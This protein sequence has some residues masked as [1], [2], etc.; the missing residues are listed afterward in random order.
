MP[1]RAGPRRPTARTRSPRR[2]RAP[3]RTSRPRRRGRPGAGRPARGSGRPGRTRRARSRRP[4]RD[5]SRARAGAAIS[6]TPSGSPRSYTTSTANTERGVVTPVPI[7]RGQREAELREGPARRLLVTQL[8]LHRGAQPVETAA[9]R[10]R[11]DRVDHA[12]ELTEPELLAS[13]HAQLHE[14][15]RS[16]ERHRRGRRLLL[17]LQTDP[18]R[19]VHRRRRQRERRAHRPEH[20]LHPDVTATPGPRDVAVDVGPAPGVAQPE[21]GDLGQRPRWPRSRGRAAPARAVARRG[22]R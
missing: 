14:A 8:E 11:Q 19:L 2:G 21:A 17:R 18:V 6:P 16:G 5:R 13:D 4:G 15:S 22:R 12:L 3:G 1:R 7:E 9:W 20:R 10:H